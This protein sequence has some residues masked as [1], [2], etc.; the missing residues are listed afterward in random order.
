[1]QYQIIVVLYV[2]FY[3]SAKE[4]PH[5]GYTKAP[6]IFLAAGNALRYNEI[7]NISHFSDKETFV[8]WKTTL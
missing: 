6:A 3:Y 4:G 2:G 8:Q 5:Q 1:M 7:S